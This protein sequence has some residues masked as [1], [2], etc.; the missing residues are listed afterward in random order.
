MSP[1]LSCNSPRK[2]RAE[3]EVEPWRPLPK[4]KTECGHSGE[5]YGM[6]LFP[7]YTQGQASP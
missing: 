4:P 2:Q 5:D 3:T 6:R 1:Q 7:I